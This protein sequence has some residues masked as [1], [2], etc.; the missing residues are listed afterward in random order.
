MSTN[1]KPNHDPFSLRGK[2]ALVTGTGRGIGAEV[3]RTL[4]AAGAQV[5]ATDLDGAA[6]ERVAA[7]IRDL[8]GKAEALAQD[9]TSED[10]WE[11]AVARTLTRLGGLDVLVNNAGVESMSLSRTPPRK[12]SGG[13]WPSTWR[14]CSWV[15]SMRCVPCGPAG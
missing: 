8:G 12:N 1:A 7:G 11:R 9:V 3:A 10:R 5:I 4:A 13:S 14:G 15:S 2:V 6:A